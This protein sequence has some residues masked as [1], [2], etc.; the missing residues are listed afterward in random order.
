MDLCYYYS[1]IISVLN[2]R[3]FRKG[4]SIMQLEAIFHEPYS[5]FAFPM[6]SNTL[7]I[8]LRTKKNDVNA[9]MLIYH[10]KYDSTQRG[11]IQMD[12][13]ASDELFDYYEV[14]LNVGIKRFKY[15][16]YLEDNFE[17]KWYNQNGFFDYMPQ[18]GFFSYSHICEKDVIEEVL[19][20][21]NSTVYNIFPDRFSRFPD[22]RETKGP[23]YG[24]NI[25][26]IIMKLDYL[27]KLGVNVIY[28]NP[29]FKSHSY[30]RYDVIDY[31]ELDP[32][33]GEK[34]E[35]KEL[36]NLCH[37]NGIRIIFDGV[38]NHS[39]DK[40]FAFRDVVQNK[41]G[42]EYRDWYHIT[43]F[44]VINYPRPNYECFSYYGGMPKLNTGN[45][46]TKNYLFDVV[47]YWT[48]EFDVD[49]WRFDAADEIARNFLRELRIKIKTLNKDVVLIGEIFDEASSWL[50]GDQFD[51]VM[52]YHLKALINDL[53]AYRSIDAELFRMRINGYIM[54]FKKKVL[55]SMVNIIGTHDTPRFLTL[56]EGSEKRFELG[57]VFQF[58]FPGVPLIYYGDEIGMK[59]EGDP[60]CRKPMIW[61]ESKWNSKLLRLYHFL[62][63]IRKRNEV[64]RNGEYR[65]L[66]VNGD[67]GILAYKR[68]NEKDRIV[69][70]MNT[71]DHKVK[72]AVELGSSFRAVKVL[73]CLKDKKQEAIE[74]GKIKLN[75]KPLEWRIYKAGGEL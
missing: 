8:R 33:F 46:E 54:K 38:F 45:S 31:Y 1:N 59:G 55:Y 12:K 3:I 66:F 35:L 69:V 56:C 9:C 73:E 50:F 48:T 25:K 17:V 43:S 72:G 70:V 62:I 10:E 58:T 32:V 39:S 57:V 49:G 37:K 16:F 21:K 53:F 64:L 18:W 7:I 5:Q 2:F 42:S 28:L 24:G 68:E 60:D 34:S 30:H 74:G 40:F 15:M 44:P 75:L 47:K 4:V 27:I 52:N 29:I 71:T 6:D 20:F 67:K 51:S 22:S 63:D 65:D 26:G 14:E 41:E 23:V 19:W 13:V 61:D 36:I 11:K